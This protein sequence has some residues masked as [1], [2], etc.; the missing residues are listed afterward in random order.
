MTENEKPKVNPAV[1]GPVT[2]S[3]VLNALIGHKG[4]VQ[5]DEDFGNETIKGDSAWA[6]VL[7]NDIRYQVKVT[8]DP[9]VPRAKRGPKAA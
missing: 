7:I 3:G 9:F 5:R 8:A 4:I 1:P 6:H 2:M